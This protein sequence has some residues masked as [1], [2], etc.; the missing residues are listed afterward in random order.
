ML[1]F[2]LAY[3]Q[4]DVCCTLDCMSSTISFEG[5]NV[6]LNNN[7]CLHPNH[8]LK[9]KKKNTKNCIFM[10]NLQLHEKPEQKQMLRIN[11]KNILNQ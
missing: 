2:N 3:K 5:K 9:L 11:I 10:K 4:V 1:G 6:N 7:K 8:Y